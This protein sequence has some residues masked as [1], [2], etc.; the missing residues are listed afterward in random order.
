ML[1]FQSWLRY[2][3]LWVSVGYLKAYF[4]AV[5]GAGILP[6]NEEG[7][8]VMLR[9]FL[10]DRALCELAGALR[11]GGEKPEIPLSG[12]LF[13][14]HEQVPED[15]GAKASLAKPTPAH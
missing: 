8:R 6:E 4:Q 13:L 1:R 14:L 2:W 3:N 7:L 9:A 12:I 5:A 10:L 15:I 11:E